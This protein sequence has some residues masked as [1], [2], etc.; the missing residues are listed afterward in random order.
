MIISYRMFVRPPFFYTNRH[1]SGVITPFYRCYDRFTD[2]RDGQGGWESDKLTV[3]TTNESQE[4]SPFLEGDHKA[5]INRRAKRHSKHKTKQKHKRRS[6][7]LSLRYFEYV[8]TQFGSLLSLK[9]EN[10]QITYP[11]LPYPAQPYHILPLPILPSPILPSPIIPC[12]TLRYHHQSC[13]L[14][15]THTKPS[16]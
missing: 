3:D 6:G 5:H 8:N 15:H 4:V 1:F 2:R 12:P 11:T 7:R 16:P 13:R 9:I 10:Q 14:L